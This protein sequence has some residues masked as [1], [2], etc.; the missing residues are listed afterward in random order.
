[1]LS[2][3]NHAVLLVFT[4]RLE[5][6]LDETVS[7]LRARAVILKHCLDHL[8]EVGTKLAAMDDRV[9][10]GDSRETASRRL[11]AAHASA[12][13]PWSFMFAASGGSGRIAGTL[14]RLAAPVTPALLLGAV[15]VGQLTSLDAG[16][17]Y[18]QA[19]LDVARVMPD[20]FGPL[21]DGL[22]ED[23][24]F[25]AVHVVQSEHMLLD[26]DGRLR[27]PHVRVADRALMNLACRDD[28][29]GSGTRAIVRAHL[30]NP[31]L[32]IR[33]K[34]WVLTSLNRVDRHPQ[35]GWGDWLDGPTVR[36][37]VGQCLT[38]GSGADRNAAAALL[39]ELALARAL[40]R[41]HWKMIA[42]TLHTRRTKPARRRP[43]HP[44]QRREA[45]VGL[46][47]LGRRLCR[48]ALH[49]ADVAGIR[50]RRPCRGARLVPPARAPLRRPA[51]GGT[52]TGAEPLILIRSSESLAT[53]RRAARSN[54]RTSCD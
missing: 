26:S 7:Q 28:G 51:I 44:H 14:G 31:D 32:P 10:L 6:H 22:D 38:A 15:A 24:F 53:P 13:D 23:R 35:P 49:R 20:A 30:M 39:C 29:V 5:S 54:R 50:S 4:E 43:H 52:R 46:P 1:M 34:F 42:T 37:M 12:R 36:A 11:R 25:A 40:T 27:T 19:A 2:T 18:D 16:V 47:A 33:G 3:T 45:A 17:S 8:D 9:G 48:V 41:R 21:E